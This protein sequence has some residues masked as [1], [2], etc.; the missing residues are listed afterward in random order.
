[1]KGTFLRENEMG[2]ELN[3]LSMESSNTS[4]IGRTISVMV[5]VNYSTFKLVV[6]KKIKLTGRVTGSMGKN[7]EQALSTLQMAQLSVRGFGRMDY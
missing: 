2:K 3:T 4:V 6:S 1:M 5:Q 7:T